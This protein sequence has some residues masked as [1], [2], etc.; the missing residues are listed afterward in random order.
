[1]FRIWPVAAVICM[2]VVICM[3]IS[4]G[5][6]YRLIIQHTRNK[7]GTAKV[8]LSSFEGD[9][10]FCVFRYSEDVMEGNLI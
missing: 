9:R 2:S 8:N 5:G 1:M 10:F 3:F 4:L 6:I 7:G